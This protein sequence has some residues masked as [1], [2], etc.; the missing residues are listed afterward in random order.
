[1]T[2]EHRF[3]ISPLNPKEGDLCVW[4]IPQIPMQ[5]FRRSVKNL[6][7]ATMLLETLAHYDLFQYELNIKPDYCNA[8]GLAVYED[9]D[10]CEWESE[11]GLDI[12]AWSEDCKAILRG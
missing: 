5:A 6:D 10:W 8:G 11:E 1:M 2:E 12:D 4:W 3:S 7:E 9:G